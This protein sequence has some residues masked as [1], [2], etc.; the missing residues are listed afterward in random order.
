MMHLIKPHGGELNELL[1]AE[2]LRESLKSEAG[3]LPSWDLNERQLCDL[4]MLLEGSFS[5]LAGFLNQADYNSVL[6]DLRLADGTVWPMPVTLDV[7]EAFAKQL[8][9]GASIALRDPEG[10]I[11]A[12]LDLQDLWRPDMALEAQTVFGTIDDTHPAVNYLLKRSHPVYLGGKLRGLQATMHY[13]FRHLRRTPR[14]MRTEF[15]KLGWSRIVAFQTRHPMHRAHQELTFLA[16]QQAEANLLIHPVV[17]LTKPG[18]IDYMTR[19]R[20]YEKLLQRFPEQTTE[21]SLLNLA[22]RMGGP[23]EALWHTIIRKNHGCTHIIIGRDHASPGQDRDG[24]DFYGPYDAQELVAQYQ[25]EIGVQMMPFKDMVYVQDRAQY[26]AVDEV[27]ESETVLKISSTEL[28]RRLREGLDI[29]EWFSYPEVVEELR[30]SYPSRDQ[31]GFTVF[32][33]GLSGAGKSTIANALMVRL[34]EM[35][36]RPVSLLDGDIVRKHLSSELGFSKEHRN[37]NVLR[38]GFVASEITKNGGVAICAPIAPFV[39]T[40]REVREMIE[41]LGGFLE[42]HVSTSLAVCEQR[43]RKG[44]YALARAGKIKEFTGISDPYDEPEAPEMRI[45]TDGCSPEEAVQ[46][47]ILKLEQVGLISISREATG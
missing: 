28:R 12:V 39:D 32:F 16:A 19:V 5:P 6:K 7:S 44:L 41:P 8:E 24:N 4:E 2:N 30:K 33:T 3:H 15:S 14:E 35:G 11:I 9:T 1:V 21:L 40:R 42:I 27:K 22:M 18:D 46:R 45:D 17:G 10:V 34:L 37:I 26:V 43:D 25:Q 36:D 23:R 20:C 47:I 13:D 31:Q 38:I 29:P